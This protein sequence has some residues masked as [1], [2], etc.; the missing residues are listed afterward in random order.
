MKMNFLDFSF[1]LLE[2][3]FIKKLKENKILNNCNKIEFFCYVILFSLN[4]SKEIIKF[5]ENLK[6]ITKNKIIKEIINE[7]ETKEK[8]KKIFNLI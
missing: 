5:L 7:F 1:D 8:I 4:Y 6:K 3:F 2:Y